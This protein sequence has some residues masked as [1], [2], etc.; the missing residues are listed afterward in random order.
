MKYLL[1]EFHG[2]CADKHKETAFE[3]GFVKQQEGI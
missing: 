3:R 1:Q 2:L